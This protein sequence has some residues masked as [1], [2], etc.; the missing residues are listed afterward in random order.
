M[1]TQQAVVSTQQA[2]VPTQQAV[3]STQ[4]AVVPTQQAVVSTQQAVVPTQPT[5]V[6]AGHYRV[7]QQVVG[8][9]A[10]FVLG[11]SPN[12]SDATLAGLPSGQTLKVYVVAT[13]EAGDSPASGTEEV[14]VP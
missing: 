3:V 12:D 6:R 9:D 1:S 4:Q 7:Y 5:I 10:D 14:V 11:V 8:V 13:N 2:V